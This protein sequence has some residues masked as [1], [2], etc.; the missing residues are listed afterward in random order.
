MVRQNWQMWIG[1]TGFS[2][3]EC[4]E[5]IERSADYPAESGGIFGDNQRSSTRVSTVKWMNEQ[6]I[7]LRLWSFI[8][9][10][11]KVFD[12][13]VTP[14]A[15]IQ[16][17]EYHGSVAG[18]YDKHHDIDWNRNDGTDRKLSVTVQLSDPNEYTGGE[19]KF[20]EIETPKKELLQQRGTVLVFPSYLLH[21]VS[22]VTSGVRRSLVSWF[23]G[24]KWK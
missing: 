23:E 6:D 24:P 13:D 10:A 22:P 9:V 1:H 14:L 12:I 18:K 20:A 4:D 8:D 11:N 3:K 16:F 15:D 19:F 7:G 17:T 21:S 2:E 5:I